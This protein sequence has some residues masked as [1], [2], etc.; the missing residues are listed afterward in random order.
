MNKEFEIKKNLLDLKYNKYLQY[1]NTAIITLVTYIITIFIAAITGQ[2]HYGNVIFIIAIIFSIL[3]ILL[4]FG[5]ISRYKKNLTFIL[6]Q[7]QNL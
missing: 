6:K 1:Y 5:L 4:L 3:I 2:I 7:I